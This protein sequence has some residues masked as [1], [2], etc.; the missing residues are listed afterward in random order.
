MSP[1]ANGTVGDTKTLC[2]VLGWQVAATARALKAGWSKER[3]IA[4]IR[5]I[6][7]ASES[8]YTL[9]D[10]KYLIHGGRINHM[11]GLIA[12][13]LRIRPLIGVRKSAEPT[14]SWA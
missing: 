1:L 10:L 9:D 7:D 12:A 13:M 4:L 14:R 5:R 3:I 2:A 8:I 6:G 11:T